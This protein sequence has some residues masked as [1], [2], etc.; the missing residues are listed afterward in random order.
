M[1]TYTQVRVV[2]L[3]GTAI[4]LPTYL[5]TSSSQSSHSRILPLAGAQEA[6]EK[7]PVA[8]V[9]LTKSAFRF[10]VHCDKYKQVR[11]ITFD[12]QTAQIRHLTILSSTGDKAWRYDGADL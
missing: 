4:Y 2:Y 9:E 7:L 3:R 1:C 10:L 11:T 12:Q 6:Y 5:P 8:V